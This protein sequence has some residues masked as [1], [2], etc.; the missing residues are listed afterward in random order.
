M[1]NE[2]YLIPLAVLK[3]LAKGPWKYDDWSLTQFAWALE[4]HREG[5]W[6]SGQT[7]YYAMHD[8]CN[9][10]M[11]TTAELKAIIKA[12]AIDPA[13]YNADNGYG[14]NQ[15]WLHSMCQFYAEC[16][17]AW[18]EH[19]KRTQAILGTPAGRIWRK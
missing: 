11:M 10:D 8:D 1:A 9:S 6:R 2:K 19:E 13:F 18:I 3:P 7:S 16:T 14:L 12:D 5:D 17:K 4:I 15:H